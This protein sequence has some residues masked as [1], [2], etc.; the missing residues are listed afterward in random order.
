MFIE[1]EFKW[2]PC[3][4]F[5][6][7][8][9]YIMRYHLVC[10]VLQIGGVYGLAIGSRVFISCCVIKRI[11]CVL[12]RFHPWIQC[13]TKSDSCS[14]CW[15][16]I[17]SHDCL[18]LRGLVSDIQ[19]ACISVKLFMHFHVYWRGVSIFISIRWDWISRNKHVIFN[20]KLINDYRFRDFRFCASILRLLFLRVAETTSFPSSFDLRTAALLHTYLP[21]HRL[22]YMLNFRDTVAY[23]PHELKQ[24]N[25]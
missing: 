22:L 23:K 4:S 6:S 18:N 16:F 19:Q 1:H 9:P 2:S 8:S 10:V 14:P 17:H 21:S 24:G 7:M 11:I 5:S 13:S 3:S 12:F 15:K 25:L 20:Q